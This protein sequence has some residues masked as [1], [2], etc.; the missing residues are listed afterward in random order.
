MRRFMLA[1]CSLLALTQPAMAADILSASRITAAT[2][3]TDRATVT[4]ETEVELPAGASTVVLENLPISLFPDSLR[5]DGTAVGGVVLGS[6]ENKLV[7]AAELIAPRERELNEKLQNLTDDRARIEAE[8]SALEARKTFLTNIG[9]QASLR[10]D[11]QIAE[12]NLKPDTWN[13]AASAIQT[14]LADVLKSQVENSIKLRRIDEQINQVQT[15]MGQ[16]QTGQRNSYTVKI[17]LEAKVATKLKLKVSYQLPQ[18]TWSPIYDARLETKDGKLALIQYGQVRQQTGEDWTDVDLTLSTAQPARGAVPPLLSTMWVNIQQPYQG[19]DGARREA[20]P[21]APVM[22]QAITNSFSA[23]DSVEMSVAGAA[24]PE[25]LQEATFQS[26]TLQTGGFVSEYKIAGRANVPA[27]NTGKKL[28]IGALDTTA[29]LVTQVRPQLTNEAFLIARTKLNGETPLLPGS[30][31]LFRDGAFIGQAPLPLLR[32]G[33][34][35]DLGFGVDDQIAVKHR[36]LLDT[37]G[38]AGM[39]SRDKTLERKYETTVQNLHNFA[40]TVEV[41]QSLPVPRNEKIT[42]SILPDATTG[43]FEKDVRNTTGLYQWNLKLEPQ[44]KDTVLLGWKLAWPADS[45]VGG[46]W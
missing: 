26:A 27:D 20:A 25:P 3:Y 6:I 18:A 34:E 41:L 44:K 22:K 45:N 39:I 46:V 21:A 36:T 42:L 7:A 10:T 29:K 8:E 11:E 28:M 9:K 19:Y 13:G 43:G 35:T 12:L 33:E 17:P 15:E 30:A 37:S 23:M 5:A 31:S 14:G 1:T 24:A 16:L 4:R 2:V 32:P 38:E 40:T